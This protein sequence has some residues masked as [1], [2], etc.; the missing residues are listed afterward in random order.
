MNVPQKHTLYLNVYKSKG[1]DLWCECAM[2]PADAEQD[3]E[4]TDGTRIACLAVEFHEGEGLP[5]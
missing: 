3:A 4:H 1:D 5:D 2:T